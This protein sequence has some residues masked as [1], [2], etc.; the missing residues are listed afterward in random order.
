[1]SGL[2]QTVLTLF[3]TG[4]LFL[5]A[6]GL[7][8]WGPC[9]PSSIWGMIFMLASMVCFAVGSVLAVAALLKKLFSAVRSAL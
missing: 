6:M 9:G 1:M 7:F 5:C 3:G 4:F 8:R 2:L